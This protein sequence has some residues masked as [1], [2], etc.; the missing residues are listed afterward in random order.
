MVHIE[1]PAKFRKGPDAAAHPYPLEIAH[2][3]LVY[4]LGAS[5]Y[6]AFGDALAG[7]FLELNNNPYEYLRDLFTKQ[8]LSQEGFEKSYSA[9][10][11]YSK[12]FPKPPFQTAL[13]AIISHWDCYI[14]KLGKFIEFA[15]QYVESPILSVNMSKDLKT[16]SRN[17]LS[18][19][20][21]IIETATG[22]NCQ[23]PENTLANLREMNLVRN[24]GLHNEWVIDDEYLK[25]SEQKQIRKGTIRI[26]LPKE[27]EIWQESISLTIN[28]TST[29]IAKKYLNAP[30][31]PTISK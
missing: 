8:G 3:A 12:T 4:T 5:S 19:Q 28:L 11:A 22:L 20:I 15:R 14:S 26:V 1:W 31:Y 9:F 17:S 2:L 21:Q 27:L 10:I 29:T 7:G 23:L 18:K 16:I 25:Y 30:E 13:I 24:L 6:A